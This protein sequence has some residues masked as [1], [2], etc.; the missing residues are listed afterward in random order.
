[1]GRLRAYLVIPLKCPPLLLR[2]LAFTEH[3][4]CPHA[5]GFIM[6]CCW[7]FT[8]PKGRHCHPLVH[9]QELISGVKSFVPGI[10]RDDWG[11]EI[12]TW[13]VVLFLPHPPHRGLINNTSFVGL[14]I[15]RQWSWLGCGSLATSSLAGFATGFVVPQSHLSGRMW[16]VGHPLAGRVCLFWGKAFL[17]Q[18]CRFM[19]WCNRSDHNEASGFA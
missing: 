14:S 19:T 9:V 10:T 17:T 18:G 16:G 15:C 6:L 7:I 1:M 12:P 8:T 11:I 3:V 2:R 5:R 4:L 13:S